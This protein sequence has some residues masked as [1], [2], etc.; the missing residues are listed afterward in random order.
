M[1]EAV[2]YLSGSVCGGALGLLVYLVVISANQYDFSTVPAI[3]SLLFGG[4]IGSFLPKYLNLKHRGL[5]SSARFKYWMLLFIEGNLFVGILV[6]LILGILASWL[7]VFS[8]SILFGHPE[9]GWTPFVSNL[10][11][12]LSLILSIFLVAIFA[13]RFLKGSVLYLEK[14]ISSNGK[15]KGTGYFKC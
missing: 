7:L 3:G 8:F 5:S 1:R 4:I 14:K 15:E 2:K 6:G 11:K 10:F 9:S 13:Y 12:I